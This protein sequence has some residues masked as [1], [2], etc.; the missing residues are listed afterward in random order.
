MAGVNTQHTKA[1]WQIT[2]RLRNSDDIAA[3]LE[4]CLEI[5]TKAMN[6][7]AGSVWLMSNKTDRL[8]VVS[9]VG[10]VDISGISV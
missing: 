10:S 1:I 4:G 6:C 9:Y 3:A 7:E 5:I 2:E 8:S